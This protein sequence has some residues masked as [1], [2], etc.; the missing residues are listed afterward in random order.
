MRG[1]FPFRRCREH[2]RLNYLSAVSACG[3]VIQPPLAYH[4][5]PRWQS[6][7]QQEERKSFGKGEEREEE[8]N[9]EKKKK[10]AEEEKE[11]KEESE[12]FVP[13]SEFGR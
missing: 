6:K 5:G 2:A 13:N 11:E 7:S 9:F 1:H 8:R 3:V 4:N 10:F 12:I